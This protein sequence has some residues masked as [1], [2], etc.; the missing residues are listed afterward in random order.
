[1]AVSAMSGAVVMLHLAP[2]PTS[3]ALASDVVA[4]IARAPVTALPVSAPAARV[5]ALAAPKVEPPKAELEPAPASMIAPLAA[6]AQVMPPATVAAAPPQPVPAAAPV[7]PLAAATQP[8]PMTLAD[9]DLT[10]SNGYARRH[11]AQRV[12]NGRRIVA[13]AV[14]QQSK[15]GRPA[16]KTRKV[17]ARNNA[18]DR[19]R[20]DTASNDT[21]RNTT[22][23]M[24]GRFD[25]PADQFDFKRHQA[26]AFGEQ[27]TASRHV[28]PAQPARPA[29]P[30]GNSPNGLFGGLF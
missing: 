18:A 28:Q 27:R 4:A 17:V 9:S 5:V 7:A 24:F 14:I 15:L 8:A 20:T 22:Y 13:Q 19:R 16:T 23:S 12:P 26:L 2:A 25:R 10:F 11:A 6:R 1:V 29:G 3:P 21:A 30:F